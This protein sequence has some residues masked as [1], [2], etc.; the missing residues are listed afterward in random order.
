MTV[1]LA[2][3]I[4]LPKLYMITNTNDINFSI[5]DALCKDL[6]YRAT[7]YDSD[8]ALDENIA[9]QYDSFCET[10][11][12]EAAQDFLIKVT[13]IAVQNIKDNKNMQIDFSPYY[14]DHALEGY[15][16]EGYDYTVSFDV[17]MDKIIDEVTKKYEADMGLE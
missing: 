17:D 9:E 3:Y 15:D 6:L 5:K 11:G 13:N 7:V 1:E 12:E 16:L 14:E 10:Y 8:S 2:G 4:D